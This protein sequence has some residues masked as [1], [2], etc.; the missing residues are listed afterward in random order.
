MTE[1]ALA[2]LGWLDVR[3]A[4]WWL[5]L[6]YRRPHRLHEAL[7]KLPKTAMLRAGAIL[8]T[9]ALVYA[10]IIAALGRLFLFGGLGLSLR[11]NLLE[12]PDGMLGVHVRQL[13]FGIA[14]GIALGIALLRAYYYPW[15]LVLRF[16][17]PTA[18]GYRLHPAAFDDLCSLPFIGLDRFLLACR[19]ADPRSG[20]AEIERLITSY[21]SQR[22]EALK[23]RS[24]VI[25]RE[26]AM[27][28]L[29]K[30]DAI[31]AKLPEGEKG[32]LNETPRVRELVEEIA[33]AQRRLDTV[34]RPFLREPYV[35][36]LI[37]KIEGFRGQISGFH[38]P[39]ASEFRGAASTW[40][41]KAR[42]ELEQ[43]RNV[44]AK[45]P[46]PQVFRAWT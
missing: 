35:E 2:D 26:A 32:F 25:A 12:G 22:N 17:A 36:T 34:D 13:A 21:P 19:E 28:D 37:S 4:A 27:C 14:A 46:T 18:A 41:T 33:T 6:L 24:A 45:E 11:E 38:E 7:E 30:I 3:T 44:T 10:V 8:F 15:H 42:H 31:T 20:D 23:A 40:L 5:G 43:V 39:L 29:G 16:F 1:R 9:H